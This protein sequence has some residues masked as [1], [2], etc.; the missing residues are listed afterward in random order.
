[1]RKIIVFLVL[2]AVNSY[3]FDPACSFCRIIAGTEQ[4]VIIAQDDDCI[5]IEK[6][7]VRTPVD[8]LIIPKKHIVNCKHLK[9]QDAYDSTIVS[10]MAFMA[11]KL[12]KRLTGS[13]DFQL[14]INN[15]ADAGQSV[16]HLHM[17]F[18]SPEKW[19]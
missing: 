7:P 1:M 19:V 13:Q 11:Q 4:A 16:F 12:S 8:C 3:A 2:L 15:G 9:S 10:K 5:V 14:H 18:K 6:K 17:H